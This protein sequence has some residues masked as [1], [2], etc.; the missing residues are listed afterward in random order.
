MTIN[1]YSFVED[2]LKNKK[3]RKDHESFKKNKYKYSEV[4]TKKVGNFKNG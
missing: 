4:K 3:T 1:T 2:F